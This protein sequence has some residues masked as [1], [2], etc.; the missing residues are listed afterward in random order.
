[1]PVLN[2]AEILP[3][4]LPVDLIPLSKKHWLFETCLEKE[5][6]SSVKWHQKASNLLVHEDTSRYRTVAT[7]SFSDAEIQ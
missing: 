4:I 3:E 7:T 6:I 5:I 1:M 2:L